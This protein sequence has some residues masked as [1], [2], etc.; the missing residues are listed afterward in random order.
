MDKPPFR[1]KDQSRSKRP[2]GQNRA[3]DMKQLIIGLILFLVSLAGN[4]SAGEV[5]EIELNDGGVIYGEILSLENDI[6]TLKTE[7]FGMVTLDASK[8]L[9]IR[10]KPKTEAAGDRLQELRQ[11]MMSDPEI[12]GMIF[13]L[14]NDP[15]I[16][17][18]LKDPELMKSLSSGD[19]GALISNPAIIKLLN[20]P[21]I[22]DI[23][24]KALK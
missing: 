7:T 15:E 11:S 9:T 2:D 21:K 20:N 3:T 18:I 6:L 22:Q 5:R 10:M 4:A 14:Q 16:Q 12:L 19:I 1:A 13:S 23:G 8:I 17:A 24:K